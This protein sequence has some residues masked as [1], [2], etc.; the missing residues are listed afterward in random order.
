MKTE[1]YSLQPRADRTC[2]WRKFGIRFRCRTMT[3]LAALLLTAGAGLAPAADFC[4]NPGFEIGT[5]ADAPPWSY[6]EGSGGAQTNPLVNVDNP[7]ARVFFNSGGTRHVAAQNNLNLILD[8]TGTVTYRVKAQYY[9]PS[10]PAGVVSRAM[11]RIH[12]IN[13]STG[14]YIPGDPILL[15][16]QVDDPANLIP[17]GTWVTQEF[18]WTNTS[19]CGYAQYITFRQYGHDAASNA[20]VTPPPDVYYDNLQF[21]SSQYHKVSGYVK[22]H[23]GVGLAGAKVQLSG[24]LD[25]NIEVVTTDTTGHYAFTTWVPE[26]NSFTVDAT[27]LLYS[28]DG[29]QTVAVTSAGA[30]APNLVMTKVPA[31]R[32]RGT[33]TGIPPGGM[34]RVTATS[35]S[36]AISASTNTAPDGTYSLEVPDNSFLTLTASAFPLTAPGQAVAVS[37]ADVTGINF[38]LSDSTLVWYKFD[39]NAND[40]SAWGKNGALLGAATIPAHGRVGGG[41]LSTIPG[42]GGLTVPML[43]AA[44]GDAPLFNAYTMSAWV[45]CTTSAEWQEL[46]AC[47]GWDLNDVNNPVFSA[48]GQMLH[49]VN[50]TVDTDHWFPAPWGT[51]GQWHFMTVTY[52]SEAKTVSFYFDGNKVRTDNFSTTV[53]VHFE[54]NAHIACWGGP[55]DRQFTGEIDDFR[56]F[57]AAATEA[58]AKTLYDAYPPQVTHTIT[59][60]AQSGATI[61]PVGAVSVLVGYDQTFTFSPNTG[62]RVT[63]VLV[64]GVPQTL[65]LA[66]YTFTNVTGSHT[67]AVQ[68]VI[69]PLHT[70]SGTVTTNGVGMPGATVYLSA[71]PNA[72][73]APLFTITTGAGGVWFQT[74]VPEGTIY[75]SAAAAGFW[76]SP[77]QIVALTADI[78]GVVLALKSRPA[79]RDIPAQSDLLFAA[80]TETLPASGSIG[81][82]PALAPAGTN[83]AK[84]NNPQVS[85]VDNQPWVAGNRST[86]PGF[87]ASGPYDPNLGV[88]TINGASIVA[89]I[90]PIRSG[91]DDAW[92]SVVDIFYGRLVLACMNPSGQVRVERQGEWAN[93]PAL[94]AGQKTILTLVAQPTGEYKVYANGL[95]VMDIASTADLTYLNPSIQDLPGWPWGDFDWAHYMMIGRNFPDNWTGFNG[96]IGDVFVYGKALDPAE[97]DRLQQDVANKFG[98]TMQVDAPILP[99]SGFTMPGGVPTF[100]F[101]T[102]TGRSYR[103]VFKHALTDSAWSVIGT[104]NWTAGTGADVTLTDSSSPLPA[105]RFYRLEMQ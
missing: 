81:N 57:S 23:A 72:S 44:S 46:Y 93:G 8:T 66:S 83:F 15:D 49:S 74:G 98:I 90:Q 9:V 67:I 37:G 87:I 5:G 95:K 14:T 102:E 82:W 4:V 88:V 35:L 2:G 52:D 22:D 32:I 61:S 89:V 27:L 39:G 1:T 24:V 18:D 73:L 7:S 38:A 75:A 20:R 47:P 79:V 54:D 63:A 40:S 103:I 28:S 92:N 70:L 84:V 99:T 58:D 86:A 17:P 25:Y 33:V 34:A 80:V 48:S 41:C 60:T 56:I 78:S 76:N 30:T 50:G 11:V 59:A 77:D 45:R 71:S 42:A 43:G 65:P 12:A 62:Y 6:W 100:V 96:N 97:L 26:G 55:G 91:P 53:P 16:D 68:A 104:G 101:P 19:G 94:P 36:P 13:T 85:I 105:G 69:A 29:P 3:G 10:N 31:Y 51:S 21:S 64:D